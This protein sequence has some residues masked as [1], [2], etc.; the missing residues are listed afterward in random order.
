MNQPMLSEDHVKTARD[1]LVAS[2][3]EFE[4]GDYLQASEKLWGAASY[5]ALALAKKRGSRDNRHRAIRMMIREVAESE[6][7]P[8][9]RAA[10]GVAEKFH[11]NFYHNFLPPDE[12]FAESREVAHQFVDAVL[13]LVNGQAQSQNGQE[14]G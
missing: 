8:F 1:F 14:S 4:A 7:A 9:L 2:D 3:E 13:E 5:A 6:G 12:E 10:Y 11:A